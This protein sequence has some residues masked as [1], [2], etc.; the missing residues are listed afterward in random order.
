MALGAK[1]EH[2]ISPGP[3]VDVGFTICGAMGVAEHI[4]TCVQVECKLPCIT[5]AVN[6]YIVQ[7]K[8][9]LMYIGSRGEG[10]LQKYL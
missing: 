8:G 6:G 10:V 5:E 1:L 9:Q 2:V 3:D 7:F 4:I